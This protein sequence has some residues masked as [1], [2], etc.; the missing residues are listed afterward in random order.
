[1]PRHQFTLTTLF[2]AV[3]LAGAWSLICQ[4][5]FLAVSNSHPVVRSNLRVATASYVALATAGGAVWT[6]AAR[7]NAGQD[8]RHRLLQIALMTLGNLLLGWAWVIGA[9]YVAVIANLEPVSGWSSQL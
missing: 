3:T 1:M 9:L 2:V 8:R 7:M 4:L 5:A 6:F